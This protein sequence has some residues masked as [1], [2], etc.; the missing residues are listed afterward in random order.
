MFAVI[1]AR[2]E[3]EENYSENYRITQADAER[4]EEEGDKR[5]RRRKK[6]GRRQ[7]RVHRRSNIAISF[8]L[9]WFKSETYIS[10]GRSQ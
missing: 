8:G 2:E 1:I 9:A 10:K 3:G 6:K 5:R 7:K 4:E